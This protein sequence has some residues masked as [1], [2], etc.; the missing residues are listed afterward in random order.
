MTHNVVVEWAPF[1]VKPGVDG[2][3]VISASEILQ[4]EFLSQQRAFLRRELLKGQ[5]G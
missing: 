4:H 1:T 5:K 2:A 3:A